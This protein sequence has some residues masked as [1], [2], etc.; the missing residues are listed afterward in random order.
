[1]KE[2]ER[3]TGVAILDSQG[4]LWS[5]PEPHRHKHI[6]ALAAFLNTSA[7]PEKS[8]IEGFTTNLGRFVD[9][10]EAYLIAQ[11]AKQLKGISPHVTPVL[12]SEDVW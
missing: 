4:R 2:L 12:Y 8:G 3:I 10:R 6:Y 11:K 1:M 9:R 5:L 7:E